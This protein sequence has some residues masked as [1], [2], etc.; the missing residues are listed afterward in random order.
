MSGPG[1]TP[2]L[3]IGKVDEAAQADGGDGEIIPTLPPVR[4]S[5]TAT[6]RRLAE[7]TA[8]HMV[9]VI[10]ADPLKIAWL[11]DHGARLLESA[12]RELRESWAANR[13]VTPAEVVDRRAG[14]HRRG[15]TAL[16]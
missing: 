1:R 7:E 11:R 9:R 16:W 10:A 5:P 8:E 12:A 13:A 2:H 3:R 15:E 6:Q 14:E 4:R